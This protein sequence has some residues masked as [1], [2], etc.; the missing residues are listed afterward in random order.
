MPLLKPPVRDN[1]LGFTC[2]IHVAAVLER[3]FLGG[4]YF[5]WFAHSLNPPQ[6][7]QSSNPLDIYIGLDQA[8]RKRDENNP[9]LKEFRTKLLAVIARELP[10]DDPQR[11][12]LMR[13]IRLAPIEMFRPQIWRLDLTQIELT[14]IKVDQSMPDWDEQYIADLREGEFE[15]IVP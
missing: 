12:R 6:N 13:E 2:K 7:G 3:E 15:I 5:V 9:K 14:R 8:I 4:K 11:R 10:K 1:T